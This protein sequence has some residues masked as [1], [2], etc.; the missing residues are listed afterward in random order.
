MDS[1]F[2]WFTI[3]FADMIETQ[4]EKITRQLLNMYI[5]WTFRNNWEDGKKLLSF[6]DF[7]CSQTA[8]PWQAAA[9]DTKAEL[10]Q[11]KLIYLFAREVLL[12]K[13]L[14]IKETKTT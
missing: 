12:V 5:L 2:S 8:T 3:L 10:L 13:K 6:I 14:E 4:I 1:E 11:L 7:R 9:T